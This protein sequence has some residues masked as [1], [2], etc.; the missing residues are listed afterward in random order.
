MIVVIESIKSIS[1]QYISVISNIFHIPLEIII[2]NSN[3]IYLPHTHIYIYTYL[4]NH[5]W[6]EMVGS[7]NR[8]PNYPR[9][10]F[11]IA[12]EGHLPFF[13]PCAFQDN[14]HLLGSRQL[15]R[16]V[17]VVKEVEGTRVDR[18]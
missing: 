13:H 15:L 17:A 16:Q 2:E 1:N 4:D 5:L 10:S 9:N 6:M 14:C 7:F 11:L 18:R 8:Y 12:G 3:T